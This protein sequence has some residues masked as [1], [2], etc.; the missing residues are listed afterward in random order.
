MPDTQAAARELVEEGFPLDTNRDVMAL[1]AQLLS[2]QHAFFAGVSKGW[3]NAWGDFPK[4]T[5]AIT[6]DTSVSQLQWSFDNGLEKRPTVC[7]RI[8]EHCGLEVMRCAYSNGCNLPDIACFK[9]VARGKFAMVQWALDQE[10]S[11]WREVLCK[12]AAAKGKLFVLMWARGN[13]CPWD[14]T[15]CREAAGTGR[16]DIL[17]WA[18]SEDCPWDSETCSKAARVGHLGILQ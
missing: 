12:A 2:N 5:R 4:T 16:L 10:N 11:C 15:V 18:R 13:G 6:A 3:R 14:G 8:A 7:E 17:Q 1:L 9:A